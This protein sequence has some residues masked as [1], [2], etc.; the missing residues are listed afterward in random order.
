MVMCRSIVPL[1]LRSRSLRRVIKQDNR[2]SHIS[3]DDEGGQGQSGEPVGI[4][5]IRNG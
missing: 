1:Y 3:L 2:L 5:L 4:A